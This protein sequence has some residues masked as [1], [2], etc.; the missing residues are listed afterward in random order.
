MTKDYFNNSWWWAL[1][2]ATFAAERAMDYALTDLPTFGL[3]LVAVL[4][5]DVLFHHGV[6]AVSGA[7]TV[8]TGAGAATKRAYM[9]LVAMAGFGFR[10]PKLSN[11]E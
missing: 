7:S 1:A 2:H 4:V 9:E 11:P 10:A 3:V 5:H 8:L 6:V